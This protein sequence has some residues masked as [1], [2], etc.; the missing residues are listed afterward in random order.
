MTITFES[1]D[2]ARNWAVDL[3]R[4]G[5]FRVEL[6]CVVEPLVTPAELRRL[7][8]PHLGGTAMCNRLTAADCPP[9]E[10]RRGPSGRIIKL[11]ASPELV[12]WVS[13]P[14][15]AGKRHDVERAGR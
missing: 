14:L 3:L 5:G 8:A 10:A 1:M 6:A 9:F 7:H 2:E 11:R 4:A 12:A 15:E 13:R